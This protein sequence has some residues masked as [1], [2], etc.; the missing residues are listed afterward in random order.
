MKKNLSEQV[1]Q[2]MTDFVSRLR[3]ED[4]PADVR[5]RAKVYILDSL[6]CSI[7]GCLTGPGK[8]MAEFF[9]S[10]GGTPEA[11]IL[12]TGERIPCLHAIYVNAYLSNV[13]DFDDTFSTWSHPGSTIVTPAFGVAEKIGGISGKQYLTA[14]VAGYEMSIRI[15]LATLPSPERYKQ[16]FGMATHQI[17]GSATVAG[18]LLSLNP[19][20]MA[21]AY[22]FA[23]MSAPVAHCRKN[24]LDGNER[25]FSWL[26]NNFGWAAMGGVL[27]VFLTQK[28]FAGPH[29][30]LDGERG[31]W[32]IRMVERISVRSFFE[33]CRNMT[34]KH[35]SNIIDAQ[36]SIP[37][38]V[39]A[40]IMGHSPHEG[41]YE[42]ALRDPEVFALSEKV[43]LEPDE[44]SDRMYLNE[45]LMPSK[46]T[47]RMKDGQEFEK[48][49]D[50]P[51]GSPGNFQPLSEQLEKYELLVSRV[52][53]AEKSMESLEKIMEIERI[54]EVAQVF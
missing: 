20:E 7:G 4:I 14:V 48:R 37:F 41:L 21:T 45:K 17:F 25:P 52:L 19:G 8:M 11:R 12:G 34:L 39:A 49:V 2:I 47:I 54:S 38:L 26:K 24:G 18:K 29:K 15:G 42:E 46:V 27:A 1:T 5:E 30:V 35:P 28:G 6:A 33:L 36:F 9:A 22:G 32:A 43:S 44:E 13:L 23:G 31:F 10:M 50:V 40:T 16:A 3:Y 51:S 53:G